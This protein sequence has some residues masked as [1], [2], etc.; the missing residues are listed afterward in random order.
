M[1][2]RY[3]LCI[4]TVLALVLI[5]ATSLGAAPRLVLQRL[6]GNF[7]TPVYF[8]SAKDNSGRQFVVEQP[9][10]ILLI[11]SASGVFL[12]IRNKV[13]AG[14][15]QGLLGLAFHPNFPS[16]GRFFVNYT[17]RPDGATVVAEYLSLIH[18]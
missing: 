1:E 4:S 14:G 3:R 16:N 17:R 8:T 15:E 12:D 5:Q 18:I 7:S 9:G 6:S 11:G 13:L 2:T 10:R